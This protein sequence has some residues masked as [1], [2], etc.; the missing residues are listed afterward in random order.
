[1]DTKVVVTAAI[2][3]AIHTP[4]MSP[5]LPITPE[6]IA[7]DAIAS[8]EAGAAE[9]HI[10][11]R[12]PK[13]GRPSSALP[14]FEEII[15]AVRNNSDVIIC[16]TTG[17]GKDMTVDERFSVVS[18]LK[19]ELA[20]LNM[21]SINFAMF[22][23]AEKYEEWKYDWEKP[24]L[25]STRDFIFRNTFG[26]IEK[27]LILMGKHGTKPELEIYDIGHLYTLKYFMDRELLEK[28]IY[29]QFV[30]GILGGIGAEL[31]NLMYMKHS[32]DRLL[33]EGSYRWSAIGAGRMQFPICSMA[34]VMGGGCRVG[35]ED[36]LNINRNTLAKSNADLVMKMIR[37]LKEFSLK[38][39]KPEEARGILGIR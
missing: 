18:A 36:N 29:L 33:G 21:G 39:A 11:A 6:Q 14:L 9:V 2:T 23:M 15:S 12:D 13:D 30:M 22:P 17:G 37:I 5:Y 25:D 10:H 35:I 32:A 16:I 1:M 7:N 31:E 26:D 8:A 34:A 24:F 4:S 20:S 27:A 38:P 28:P 19:P 3:G